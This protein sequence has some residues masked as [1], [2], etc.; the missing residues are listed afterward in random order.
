M[1][2]SAGFAFLHRGFVMKRPYHVIFLGFLFQATLSLPYAL[3]QERQWGIEWD[4]PILLSDTSINA[5]L[6]QIAVSGDEI[7]HVTW[8]G[9]AEKWPYARSTDGGINF[10]RSDI[11]P[12]T[13][14]IGVTSWN[15]IV[16]SGL[17]VLSFATPPS[18]SNQ[19]SAMIVAKSNDGGA[20]WGP[21]RTISDSSGEIW[22]PSISGDTVC[23]VYSQYPPGVKEIFRSTD[24]G[25]TW[26]RTN[27]HFHY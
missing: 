11:L 17:N 10:V 1:F 22:S 21:A 8:F 23:L 24:L 6:P 15:R 16:A 25:N 19:L 20:S 4:P 7:V 3:G 27:Q 18:G 13:T 5:F 9:G 14:S 2:R 12:D 26:T